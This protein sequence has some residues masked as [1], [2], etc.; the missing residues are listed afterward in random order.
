MRWHKMVS[1]IDTD[2][3]GQIKAALN[4]HFFAFLV[5]NEAYCY[6]I[7]TLSDFFSLFKLWSFS[8]WLRN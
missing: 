1:P 2:S 8:C 3:M 6:S 5:N 7:M 4:A